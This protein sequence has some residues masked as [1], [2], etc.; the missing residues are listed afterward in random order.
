MNKYFGTRRFHLI[1]ASDFLM[2]GNDVQIG[3]MS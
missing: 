2:N 3:W 1:G